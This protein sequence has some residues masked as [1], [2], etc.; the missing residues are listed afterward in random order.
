[1][2][3]ATVLLLAIALFAGVPLAAAQSQ[4]PPAPKKKPAKVW[5]NEDLSSL[6]GN[7]NTVGQKAPPP[8]EAKSEQAPAAAGDAVWEELDNL[9]QARAKVEKNLEN[10]RR[11]LENLNEE[12]R[13]TTDPARLDS[14]L[15]ARA[16]LEQRIA[17]YEEQL[18]PL[19]AEIAA[20]EKLTKGKK[21]PAK[22]K[23][24]APAP[25]PATPEGEAPPAGE[26]PPAPPPPAPGQEPPPPPPPPP[27]L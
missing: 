20:M 27:N 12:Y 26:Q 4:P 6:S 7:I 2:R 24:A 23:P 10:N 13:K 17:G 25:T 5:T 22:A 21:R 14:I 18:P 16:E 11:W 9:H 15:Q 19:N 3:K 1:M 8:A